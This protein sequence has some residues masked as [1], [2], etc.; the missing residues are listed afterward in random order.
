MSSLHVFLACFFV[1]LWRFRGGS[2]NPSQWAGFWQETPRHRFEPKRCVFSRFRALVRSVDSLSPQQGERPQTLRFSNILVV[3][4][5]ASP[6]PKATYWPNHFVEK[7]LAN[8][9]EAR[10]S[11]SKLRTASRSSRRQQK[12]SEYSRSSRNQRKLLTASRSPESEQKPPTSHAL[13]EVG[14]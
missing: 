5:A 8:A 10:D 14:H 6:D 13:S 7:K 3:V 1:V 4:R 9:A 2:G 12:L 11:E